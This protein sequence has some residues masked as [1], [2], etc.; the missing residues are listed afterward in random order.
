[1]PALKLFLLAV[2]IFVVVG[3]SNRAFDLPGW[4]LTA[5]L[6]VVAVPLVLALLYLL[7]R[8]I[9]WAATT[10]NQKSLG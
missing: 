7:T 9:R 10:G 6:F 1:M 8:F 3:I 5:T 4:F 2:V